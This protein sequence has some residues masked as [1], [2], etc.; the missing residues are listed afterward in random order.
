[1]MNLLKWALIFSIAFVM[2]WVLIF[3]FTQ[4]PFYEQV[5][6]KIFSYQTPAVPMYAYVSGAFGVGL[7][8]GLVI[9]LYYYISK[10]AE[11]FKRAR[12]I[13]SLE[14]EL[15]SLKSSMEQKMITP[16]ESLD[17]LPDELPI[18]EDSGGSE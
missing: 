12:K 4:K 14:D 10:Q 9:A 5:P 2:A 16:P 3:T 13:R 18:D 11:L 17:T 8:L 7:L 1:M 6:A 15:D